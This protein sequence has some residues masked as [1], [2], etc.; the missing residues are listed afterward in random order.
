MIKSSYCLS[1]H[2]SAFTCFVT[3]TSLMTLS[4][5]LAGE[6]SGE[7]VPEP[8]EGAKGAV[9]APASSSSGSWKLSAGPV[10]RRLGAIRFKTGATEPRITSAFGSS[11]FTP[12]SGI[13]ADTGF[14]DRTY[15]DGFVHVGA[16]TAGTGLTTNWG[17]Q[18]SSQVQGDS[19]VMSKA[20]G[21]RR[22]VSMTS[23]AASSGWSESEETDVGPYLELSYTIPIRE[24][25]SM[26]VGVNFM[27][28]NISGSQGGLNTFGQR[29]TV[30]VYDV[31]A[32]D[33]YGLGGVIPPQSPYSGSYTGPG[34]LIPNEPGDRS[35]QETLNNTQT[36]TFTD[37][38]DEDL[39]LDLHT[40]GVGC[41]LEWWPSSRSFLQ[42][43]AGIAVNIA[44]WSAERD[45]RIMQ[46]I[47]GGAATEYSRRV[48]D[49]G[50]D[51]IL[52]GFYLQAAAG[53]QINEAWSVQA[54]GRYDWNESLDGDVGNSS[55]DVDLD[56]WSSGISIGYRF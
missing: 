39:D 36:T 22:E 49:S 31:T 26:G 48:H 38:I 13:G 8:S 3:F 37:T 1:R 18:S 7:P 35:F 24:D 55:F 56:G 42:A 40:I 50:D 25:L 46:S 17:Y 32:V 9:I 27:S 6:A 11:S 51:D 54:F 23:S 14:S 33:S 2:F 5:A 16:A 45:E 34:P 4:D 43:G 52:L 28:T 15:D 10:M 30:D 29:Q 44:D 47:N 53:W 19:L 20:G 21:Q 41:Q 12:P